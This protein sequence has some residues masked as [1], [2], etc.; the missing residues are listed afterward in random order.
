MSGSF[1]SLIRQIQ[2]VQSALQ[3]AAAHA[4]NA[5][6]TIRNWLIG[7]YIVEFLGLNDRASMTKND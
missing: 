1:E 4:V 2:S 6:L 3:H 7:Y 5:G